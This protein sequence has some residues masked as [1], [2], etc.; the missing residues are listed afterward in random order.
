[1]LHRVVV[2]D[3]PIQVQVREESASVWLARGMYLSV[4]LEVR[5]RTEFSA[6]RAWRETAL[7]R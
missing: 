5:G 4:P 2:H 1:M 7:W 6:L 3:R